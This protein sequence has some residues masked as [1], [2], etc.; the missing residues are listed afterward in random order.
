M[1][2]MICIRMKST[3]FFG[4]QQPINSEPSLP[5]F[6]KQKNPNEEEE[7]VTLTKNEYKE[8]IKEAYKE[9]AKEVLQSNQVIHPERR[10]KIKDFTVEKN[11]A[12][13]GEKEATKIQSKENEITKQKMENIIDRDDIELF[14][15]TSVFPFQLFPDTITIDTTKVTII[16]KTMF[17]TEAILSCTLKDLSDVEV[18]TA[19]TLATIYIRYMPQS[20]SPGMNE[21]KELKITA[22]KRQDAMKAKKIL[23]GV[24]VAK[25][26]KINIAT[27][28]PE[29]LKKVLERFGNSE[30][31]PQ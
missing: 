27:L 10:S 22:I 6:L 3:T 14:R 9:G 7:K 31:L 17:A 13:E 12:L 18:Q 28:S 25:A 23:R 19:F 24:L 1:T 20:N 16:Q 30:A 2:S 5:D 15:A 4:D 8:V 26:E 29:E 11:S 21:P